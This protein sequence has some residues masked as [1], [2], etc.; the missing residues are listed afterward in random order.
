[1]QVVLLATDEEPKLHPLTTTRPAALLPIVNRP[2]MEI[3][4]E[5]LARAGLKQILV[6]LYERS[7][8][9]AAY[10]GS[11]SRWG[12]QIQYVH[13]RQAL[14]SA[15]ALKWAGGLLQEPFLVLRADAVLDLDITAAWEYHRAHQGL[16]TLIL[17]PAP[18]S[19]RVP[20]VQLDP[21]GRLLPNTGVDTDPHPWCMTGAYIFAPEI[22]QHIPAQ[23]HFDAERQLLPALLAAGID[24]YGYQSQ[25]YWNPLLTFED[26]HTAQH[27]FL[28][29]AYAATTNVSMPAEAPLARV[30]Y[31]SIAGRQVAP[32]IWV[33]QNHIIHPSARLAPP[34]CIGE[35]CR[36]GYQAE[37]GPATVLGA[38]VIIDDEATIRCSSILDYTYVG[39]LVHIDQRIVDQTVMIEPRSGES[40][41]VV[42]SFLLMAT[43][44]V[45]PR[46]GRM[47]QLLTKLVALLLL[48]FTLPL[49][50][51]IG[52]II[53]LTTGQSC[54]Q[55]TPRIGRR[56]QTHTAD[57]GAHHQEQWQVF[58]LLHFRT[59]R[60]DGTTGSFGHWLR[61]WELDR[62]PELLNVL[63]GDMA[64]VGVTPL[65]PDQVPFFQEEWQQCRYDYLAGFTGLWYIDLNPDSTLE[66]K[67][68]ADVY[69]V[70]THSWK[71][72][73]RII[74]HTPGAWWQHQ[75][76]RH[77]RRKQITEN[78]PSSIDNAS[79]T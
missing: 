19:P 39:R 61:Q 7:G 34:L 6:S 54:F 74:W 57:D 76:Y 56:L 40:L 46:P 49:T 63:K 48:L 41:H 71:Q 68:V 78:V 28:Y 8:H 79:T 58:D 4:L 2:V 1:M 36:I 25:D 3:A 45:K 43:Q 47:G 33:G 77:H 72:N 62:L 5:I 65:D 30:R 42:D 60:K 21:Q 13:Q 11:G 14:G 50:L 44:P 55:R 64:L 16:A 26:Y 53:C 27:V 38:N 31:P 23:T 69:Y 22:L 67:I 10:F 15:G 24:V 29:S 20:T 17:H 9:I 52:L 51:L 37:L 12:V 59:Q 75:R 73:L 18:A 32:G 66:E 70:A 35:N